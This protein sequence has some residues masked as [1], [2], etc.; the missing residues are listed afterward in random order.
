MTYREL[1]KKCAE[2]VNCQNCKVHEEC[3][4]CEKQ[5]A[6][7]HVPIDLVKSPLWEAIRNLEVES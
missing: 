2:T 5:G 4:K 3:L 6:F 1:A 7:F